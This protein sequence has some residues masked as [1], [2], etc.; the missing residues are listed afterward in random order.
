MLFSNSAPVDHCEII[1]IDNNNYDDTYD[2]ALK[3]PILSVNQLQIPKIKF[4]GVLLDPQLT[5][6]FM[7]NQSL[8]K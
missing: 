2:P 6:V 5:F 7:S 3:L 4:L 8:P 1:Y